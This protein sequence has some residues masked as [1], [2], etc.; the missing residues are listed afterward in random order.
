MW[1]FK[2]LLTLEILFLLTAIPTQNLP[3]AIQISSSIINFKLHLFI[4]NY[5]N[6]KK[7]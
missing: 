1:N 3:G 5:S 6:I 4:I 7:A 2:V